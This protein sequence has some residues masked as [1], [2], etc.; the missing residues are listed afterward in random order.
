VRDSLGPIWDGWRVGWYDW[1]YLGRPWPSTFGATEFITHYTGK[2]VA[3][4]KT[5]DGKR[6]RC[7]FE[8]AHP[9]GG[10]SGGGEGECQLSDNSV[11]NVELTP[12]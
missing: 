7:R 4:L 5:S 11:M 9:A 2:V 1:P 12:S 3:N 6:M 8:L 10:L